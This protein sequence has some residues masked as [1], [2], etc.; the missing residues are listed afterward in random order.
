MP[1]RLA[2]AAHYVIA[3]HPGAALGATKLNKVLW[4]ADCEFYRRHGVSITGARDY[5]RK[6]NGPC[7]K[8][9]EAV[10]AKMRSDGLLHEEPV[11]TI[12]GTTRRQM[13]STTDPD[14]T[15]FSGEEI[16]VLN[17]VAR[18]ITQL[19]ADEASELSHDDLWSETK[20]NGLMAVA[21]GA[22]KSI[23]L[24]DNLDDW[25]RASFA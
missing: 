2:L 21:A 3:R 22:V 24:P 19:T 5:V 6:P 25:A 4:F 15:T 10:L 18:A 12:V 1:D 20:A 11:K 14:L 13:Y 23:G 7:A 17:E 16:D 9:L 8:G